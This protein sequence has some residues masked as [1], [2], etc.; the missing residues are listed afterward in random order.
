MAKKKTTTRRRAQLHCLHIEDRVVHTIKDVEVLGPT[1]KQVV[2][3]VGR[4]NGRH[5]TSIN[6]DLGSK[7]LTISGGNEG[8]YIAFL[9]HG[10][11]E[12][13]YNLLSTRAP[14][15]SNQQEVVVVAG[16][17]AGLF[18]RRQ[19]LDFKTVLRAARHFAMHGTKCPSL[20]WEKQV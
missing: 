15:E 20:I 11:D 1:V 17:Q 6:L 18:P 16:Q 2:E 9:T 3:A 14:T 4:L 7:H 5:T 19:V 13:F 10:V 8:R 12:A